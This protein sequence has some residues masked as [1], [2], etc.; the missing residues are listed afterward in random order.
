MPETVPIRTIIFDLSEVLLTGLKGTE[1][2]LSS[3]INADPKVIHAAFHGPHI[4]RFFSGHSFEDDF[5]HD[6]DRIGGWHLPLEVYR[7]M[8]RQ[9]FHEIEGVRPTIVDLRHRGMK[10]GLLSNHGKEWVRDI[11]SRF[12][13]EALFDDRVYSCDVGLLKPNRSIY[14][15]ALRRLFAEPESTLVIDDH[16]PNLLTARELG[17]HV[18]QFLS[19]HQLKSDLKS[20]IAS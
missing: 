20:R 18:Q 16:I 17:C 5:W 8:V 6:V 12:D 9:N 10:V 2:A 7:Q 1:H 11:T 4:D 14:E 15:L 3:V 19:P 13:Y